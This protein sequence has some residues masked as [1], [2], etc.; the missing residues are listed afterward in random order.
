MCIGVPIKLLERDE[1]SGIGEI[2]GVQRR[3]SLA[4]L[5]EAKVGDYIL[6]HAGSGMKVI[7]E[8]AAA[9]T[10]AL[11]QKIQDETD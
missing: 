11:L 5:P 10:I 7:D 2:E 3:V 8:Q 9:E 4:L 6:I 1:Y